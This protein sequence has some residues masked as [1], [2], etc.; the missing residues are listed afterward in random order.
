[1]NCKFTNVLVFAVGAAIGS[2]VTWKFLK[3]KYE[4]L[5]QEEIESVKEAFNDQLTNLQEQVDEY[6]TVDKVEEWLDRAK[7][8]RINW[9]E[10]EDIEEET[11]ES[12][13]PDDD[14]SEYERLIDIY[15]NEKGGAE[16]MEVRPYVISPSDFGEMD[17]YRQF[18]LTYYEDG[19]LEDDEYNIINENEI[20]ELI[21]SDSLFTF[22]EYEDD[23]VFVR[24]ER[25]RADFEIL[26]DYRTYADA[27]SI[28]PDQVD[29]E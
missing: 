14:M 6:S 1:M 23:S 15:T 8:Q 21:G 26:K 28:G 3:T 27:R 10:L 13:E 5:A 11:E 18:S 16:D 24:N 25:L 29:D 2:A 4:R 12:E 20:A 22:G 19:V 9:S 17:G 7:G